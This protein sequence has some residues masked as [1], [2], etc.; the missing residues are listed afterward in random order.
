MRVKIQDTW[1]D[2][3]IEPICLQFSDTEQ[4]QISEMRPESFPE[5]KFAVFPDERSPEEM[6]AWMEG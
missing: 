1:Y 2:S 5:R 6:L 4:T 3:S